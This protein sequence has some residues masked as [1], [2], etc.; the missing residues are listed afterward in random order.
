MLDLNDH[1]VEHYDP[2]SKDGFE[3]EQYLETLEQLA[4]Q[5]QQQRLLE[6]QQQQHQEQKYPGVTSRSRPKR[7]PRSSPS[8]SSSAYSAWGRAQATGSAYLLIL[9]GVICVFF[10]DGFIGIYSI[11]LGFLVYMIEQKLLVNSGSLSSSSSAAG[12]NKTFLP[13]SFSPAVVLRPYSTRS[14]LY[15][16]S[17]APCFLRAPNYSGGMCLFSSGLTYALAA[18]I[19]WR[20]QRSI[21]RKR[22]GSEISRSVGRGSTIGGTPSTSKSRVGRIIQGFR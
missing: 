4:V 10:P 7:N 12:R 9:G 16:I 13:P 11:I 14:C 2:E 8:S 20:K 3:I 6:Q 5:H 22:I 17:A 1:Q 15:L 21:K 19:D 18:I